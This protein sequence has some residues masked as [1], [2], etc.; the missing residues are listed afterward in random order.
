MRGGNV[1]QPKYL[2]T[3]QAAER[4]SLSTEALRKRCARAATR[5]GRD[6]IAELGDGVTAVKM[7]RTWRVKFPPEERAA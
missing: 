3:E 2:T 1:S 6:I 7:G 5:R 4:L